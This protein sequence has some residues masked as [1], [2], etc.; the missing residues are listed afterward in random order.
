MELFQSDLLCLMIV[1]N[2]TIQY[3]HNVSFFILF[4]IDLLLL[5]AWTWIP[6]STLQFKFFVHEWLD[7]ISCSW[8]P[9]L[10]VYLFVCF[11]HDL[12][13]PSSE[14]ISPATSPNR[15][16]MHVILRSVER[17]GDVRR[18]ENQFFAFAFASET[19][20]HLNLLRIIIKKCL[21]YSQLT[22]SQSGQLWEH[23][24]AY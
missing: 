2:S 17:N 9:L 3:Y 22:V 23:F 8:R 5:H 6:R 20:G 1:I 7:L 21:I 15:P 4:V 16:A 11:W 24:S 14:G 19:E 18:E 12:S 13:H 10:F